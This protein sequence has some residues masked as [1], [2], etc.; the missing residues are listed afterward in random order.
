MISGFEKFGLKDSA[1]H[2]WEPV[3]GAGEVDDRNALRAHLLADIAARGWEAA[4]H[5]AVPAKTVWLARK[6]PRAVERTRGCQLFSGKGNYPANSL[7]GGALNLHI[8]HKNRD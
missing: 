6:K 5:A 3:A 4:H 2:G 7:N 1:G 8:S